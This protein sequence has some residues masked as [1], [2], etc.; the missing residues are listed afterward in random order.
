MTIQF[1]VFAQILHRCIFIQTPTNIYILSVS[2]PIPVTTKSNVE[3]VATCLLGVGVCIQPG[4]DMTCDGCVA[5]L[6][7]QQQTDLSSRGVL[8]S[9]CVGVCVWC[10]CVCVCKEFYMYKHRCCQKS[11][12]KDIY[13][14]PIR[15]CAMLLVAT[16]NDT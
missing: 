13:H 6:R 12:N 15:F 4:T 14:K 1:I 9:E 3:S 7:Y 5:R 10:V 16:I 11:V 8:L 2:Q